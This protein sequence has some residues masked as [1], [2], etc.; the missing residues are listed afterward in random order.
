MMN[1][2]SPP[3]AWDEAGLIPPVNPNTTTNHNRSPYRMTPSNFVERF[4]V[5]E[6]RCALLADFLDLRT[7]LYEAR[8][9]QG[10]QWINGSFAE[11]VE[12]SRDRAPNDIDVVTFYHIP[13][14]YGTQRKLRDA[15]PSLFESQWGA[16]GSIHS[17]FQHL[18]SIAPERLVRRTAYWY[19]LWSHTREGTWKGFL[20]VDLAPDEDVKARQKLNEGDVQEG[21]QS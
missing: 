20:E 2:E 1:H 21:H 18:N 7:A 15:H 14:D 12:V 4:G 16:S 17:Y 3:F 11:H 6:K 13:D 5:T 10:F 19:S 9:V 8:L